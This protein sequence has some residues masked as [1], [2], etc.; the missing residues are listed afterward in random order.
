MS[1]RDTRLADVRRLLKQAVE[2][3]LSAGAVQ[4]LKWFLYTLEH[5]NNVSLACRHFGIARSTF[6]R[7]WNRF[8]AQNVSSLEETSRRPHA[9]RAPETDARTVAAIR[10]LRMA[11]PTTGKVGIHTM[12][13]EIY[14]IE[15][16][17]S[18]VGRVIA[19]H[20]LFFGEKASHLQKRGE[21]EIVTSTE[22]DTT[23]A[24]NTTQ[25]TPASASETDEDPLSMLPLP[26]LPTS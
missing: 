19:R 25:L 1:A 24:I 22:Q 6:M 10:E 15:A 12:L 9:V 14:G 5:D 4:R 20:K 26:P 23:T 18:T 8:D 13:R 11:H 7:W 17:V 21:T 16:S 2:L 3:E